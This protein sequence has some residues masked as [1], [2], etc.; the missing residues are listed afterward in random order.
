MKIDGRSLIFTDIHWGKQRDSLQNLETCKRVIDSIVKNIESMNVDNVIF[1]GDWYHNRD[2]LNVQ[3]ISESYNAMRKLA[4]VANVYFVLGNHDMYHRNSRDVNSSSMFRDIKNVTI[5]ENPEIV[6]VNGEKCLMAPYMTDFSQFSKGEFHSLFGH[7]EVMPRTL[8][9]TFQD[10]NKN[11]ISVSNKISSEI[12]CM[13]SATPPIEPECKD[14]TDIDLMVSSVKVGGVMWLGHIHQHSEHN[15]KK[16]KQIFVGAPWQQDMS[17]MKSNDGFYILESDMSYS[18][19]EILEVPHIIEINVSDVVRT[20]VDS[21][22]FSKITGNTVHVNYDVEIDQVVNVELMRRISQSNPHN[23]INPGNSVQVKFA[24]N[25]AKTV[26]DQKKTVLDFIR[27]YVDGYDDTYVGECGFDSK[28]DMM[29]SIIEYYNR[30]NES[31][32]E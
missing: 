26:D 29:N 15:F 23:E 6:Y 17:E 11:N 19:H 16:R 31:L 8:V 7:L 30:A 22:D 4:S 32:R 12:D 2:M 13:L 25:D 9:E 24:K 27:D 28:T 3:T 18:F 14:E 20:G 10:K 5:F 1:L 21:F